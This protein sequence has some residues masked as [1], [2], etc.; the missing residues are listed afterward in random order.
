[1]RGIHVFV[2]AVVVCLLVSPIYAVGQVHFD[3]GEY[4]ILPGQTFQIQILLDMDS[5][6]AGDQIPSAG[7]FSM[8]TMMTWNAPNAS[9]ADIAAIVLPGAL[10]SNGVGGLPD[11]TVG[12]GLAG[13]AG[14]LDLS[15]TEGYKNSLLATISITD[16]SVPHTYPYTLSLD[17]Y[18]AAPKTNF[19]DFAGNGL[20]GSLTFGTA[21]VTP[22]PATLLLLALGGLAL[23]RRRSRRQ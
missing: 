6:A 9:V 14:A 20:D 3:Q 22:E 2:S 11:K 12:A 19:M 8:G 5:A 13:F 7:L 4:H 18:Y 1:M 15:A 21:T 10:N 17:K 16:S 23:L